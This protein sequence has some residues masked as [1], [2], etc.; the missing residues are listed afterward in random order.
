MGKLSKIAHKAVTIMNLL[1][2][3]LTNLLSDTKGAS[4]ALTHHPDQSL[5]IALSSGLLKQLSSIELLSK[6]VLFFCI[7]CSGL[8]WASRLGSPN[9]VL[10]VHELYLPPCYHLICPPEAHQPLSLGQLLPTYPLEV[11]LTP[12]LGLHACPCDSLACVPAKP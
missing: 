1:T 8:I 6:Q 10:N 3:T 9:P 4:K 5:F 7:A 2:E 11:C 12:S